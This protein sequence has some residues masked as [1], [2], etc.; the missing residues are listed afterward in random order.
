MRHTRVQNRTEIESLNVVTQMNL[1]LTIIANWSSAALS[2]RIASKILEFLFR[3]RREKR[4][5][6]SWFISLVYPLKSTYEKNQRG[7]SSF[8]KAGYRSRQ[9]PTRH[10]SFFS[11]DASSTFNTSTQF[12]LCSIRS[13]SV[14]EMTMPIVFLFRSFDI[15]IFLFFPS[16]FVLVT[17]LW[18]CGS[19]S[20]LLI[21]SSQVRGTKLRNLQ[22]KSEKRERERARMKERGWEK[23]VLF[24]DWPSTTMSHFQLRNW[25]FRNLCRNRTTWVF[26]YLRIKYINNCIVII[27]FL[28]RH[29][30]SIFIRNSMNHL[31]VVW[32]T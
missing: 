7:N 19:K 16:V 5:E 26:V 30:I 17:E 12:I 22:M 1:A 10:S 20:Q 8:V 3:W 28:A 25:G 15:F 21:G 4:E 13:E 2:G 24:G 23:L 29:Q 9:V 11:F 27:L 31:A 6:K 18:F 14:N 32:N